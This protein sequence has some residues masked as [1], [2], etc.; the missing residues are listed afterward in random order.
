MSNLRVFDA[1]RN[2]LKLYNDGEWQEYLFDKGVK[3]VLE[4]IQR[5]F[6]NK[7]ECYLLRKLQTHMNQETQSLEA[8]LLQY[9]KFLACFELAPYME[10]SNDYEIIHNYDDDAY[11]TPVCKADTHCFTI[12]DMWMPKYMQ[13]RQTLTL[14]EANRM[15]RQ[16]KDILLRN[17][18]S[19]VKELNK[20]FMEV[21]QADEAFK[22][23]A[24]GNVHTFSSLEFYPEKDV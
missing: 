9:Y 17:T 19:N 8:H 13:I 7:Y 21:F 1:E 24:L 10:S 16:V 3:V 11:H 23:S 6:F 20:K 4:I 12:Q 18:K 22:Q 2:K 5:Y 14:Y 15:S